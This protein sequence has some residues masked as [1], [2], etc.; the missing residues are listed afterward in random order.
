MLCGKTLRG[1]S[2]A[3]ELSRDGTPSL[4]RNAVSQS[5]SAEN[6]PTMNIQMRLI[7]PSPLSPPMSKVEMQSEGRNSDFNHLI[8]GTHIA[9]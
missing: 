7:L 9:W 3:F 5:P 8:F 4:A 1:A 6:I 2:L